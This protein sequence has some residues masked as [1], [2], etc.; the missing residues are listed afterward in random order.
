M[1]QE[2]TPNLKGHTPSLARGLA[3][4][5]VGMFFPQGATARERD[6]SVG[7]SPFTGD[8]SAARPAGSTSPTH[9]LSYSPRWLFG[10]FFSPQNSLPSSFSSEDMASDFVSRFPRTAS[11]PFALLPGMNCTCSLQR[12]TLTCAPGPCPPTP[13]KHHSGTPLFAFSCVIMSNCPSVL[14][15]LY[16]NVL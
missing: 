16:A 8:L 12:S 6:N 5:L 7:W 14:A 4:G 11:V 2:W 3:R 9:T 1:H 15:M 13:L 10:M